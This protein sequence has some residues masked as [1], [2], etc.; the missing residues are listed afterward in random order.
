M[1]QLHALIYFLTFPSTVNTGYHSF[2][3]LATFIFGDTQFPEFS[4]VLML[5]DVQ[6]GYY[7][8][9]EKKAI[10][11]V[12]SNLKD[13]DA[14]QK[15]AKTVMETI[16]DGMKTQALH[17]THKYNLTNGVNVHQRITGCEFSESDNSGKMTVKDAFNGV[18]LDEMQFSKQK[19]SHQTNGKWSEFFNFNPVHY[20]LVY[21]NIY[22]PI[23]ISALKRYLHSEKNIVRRKVKPRVRLLQRRLLSNSGGILVTCL[24]TGFYPRHINLTLLRD[25][26][27][28]SE[29]QITGGIVLP[30]CDGTYQMRKSLEVSEEELRGHKYTCTATHLSLDNKIDINIEYNPGPPIAVIV[31][32]I[33]AVILLCVIAM[34]IAVKKC[35]TGTA[36][37]EKQEMPEDAAS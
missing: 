7:D 12:Y 37:T 27:S 22:Y 8:S 31:S 19:I 3:A 16:Y 17:L 28:M 1:D 25:G 18:K 26:Q 20:E 21:S 11:R 4:A 29:D 34:T 15:D 13:Y 10:H 2:F 33:L 35:R 14:E 6:V 30:N 23:C 5:D 9:V 36:E 32:S 24:A